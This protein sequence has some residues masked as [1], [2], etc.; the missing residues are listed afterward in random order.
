MPPRPK[1]FARPSF[2]GSEAS[3]SFLAVDA[4]RFLQHI[5]LVLTNVPRPF[6]GRERNDSDDREGCRRNRGAACERGAR[7]SREGRIGRQWHRRRFS[8][9]WLNSK[10]ALQ[11]AKK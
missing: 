9:S 4:A 10:A 7:Y 1:Q 5:E 6:P 8:A 3:H 2:S 11:I